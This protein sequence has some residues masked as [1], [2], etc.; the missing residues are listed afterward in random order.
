M[1]QAIPLVFPSMAILGCYF[2][3]AQAVWSKV[4][5]YGLQHPY[6]TDDKTDKFICKLL[7]LPYLL[8]EHI[9]TIFNALRQ[10]AA[11]EPLRKLTDYIYNTWIN[12]TIWPVTSWSV[13]EGYTRTNND[14]E[15][16][17]CRLNKKA[18]KGQLYFH[19]L[20]LLL[21]HEAITVN[22]QVSL[23]G[24]NKLTCLEHTKYHKAQV[25]I[26]NAWDDYSNQLKTPSQVLKLAQNMCSHQML[27]I[28]FI[29]WFFWNIF[30][31]N[32][33]SKLN[34]IHTYFVFFNHYSSLPQLSISPWPSV[35]STVAKYPDN[36]G[37]VAIAEWPFGRAPQTLKCVRRG[38][39]RSPCN[40]KK[41]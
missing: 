5:E 2:H 37:Q 30:R 4:Q 8:P 18:K 36:H 41:I 13:F 39:R 28:N 1:W 14:V 40:Y 22:L 24:E 31:V 11:T 25:D 23:V 6:A 17:H 20:L 33:L 19:V 16:W 3:W 34:F 38:V 10:K 15:G 27:I 26:F 12:S 21:H 35:L 9:I 29:M 7:S 32:K